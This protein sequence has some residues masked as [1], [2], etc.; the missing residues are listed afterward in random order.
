MASRARIVER[1]ARGP[2]PLESDYGLCFAEESSLS[3]AG[4]LRIALPPLLDN[5][6]PLK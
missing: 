3:A 5:E 1:P 2:V 6:Q 4:V